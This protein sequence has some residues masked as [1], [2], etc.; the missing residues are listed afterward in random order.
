MRNMLT[1]AM[2]DIDLVSLLLT[3][4]IF[5]CFTVVFADFENGNGGWNNLLA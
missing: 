2:P 3:L 4:K 5:D 1:I